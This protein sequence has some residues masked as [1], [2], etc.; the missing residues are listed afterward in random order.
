MP[1]GTWWRG[2]VLP[3]LSPLATFSVGQEEDLQFIT[4]FSGLPKQD[5]NRRIQ[6]GNRPY[7]ASMGDVPVAY[8]WVAIRTGAISEFQLSFTIPPRTCY[9]WDFLTLPQWRGCG[10]YPHFLQ[11]IIHLE[12]AADRFWIG[13]E[14]GNDR[15]A[16]SI[17]KAG[18]HIVSDLVIFN[19]R[20]SGLTLFDASEHAQASADFF[21]LPI[22]A[23]T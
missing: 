11:E 18:F 5:V 12:Q 16:R 14:L 10:I 1:F 4:G 20:V 21:Q 15:A 13:Y 2:D 7:I 19:G 8:G 22:V 9:L 6:N 3:A 17:K 23:G